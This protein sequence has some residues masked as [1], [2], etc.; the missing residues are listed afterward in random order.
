MTL[1]DYLDE[2]ASARPVPG[3]GGVAA[4]AGAL[5]C[6]LGCMVAQL[7]IGRHRAVLFDA[8]VR[9]A[10]AHCDGLRTRMFELSDADAEGFR[11]VTTAL[12]LPRATPAEAAARRTTLDEALLG[13]CETPLAVLSCTLETLEVLAEL[14]ECAPK[15][16]V[17][18]AGVAAS[19]ARAAADGAALTVQANARLMDNEAQACELRAR[20]HEL[21][22]QVQLRSGEIYALAELRLS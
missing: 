21:T 15:L 5:A 9:G 8:R 22:Q 20:A 1:A 14:A 10:L 7:T 4:L 16:V 12:K 18:D 2:V 13:A 6:A 17:A 3:G 11:P 19:L